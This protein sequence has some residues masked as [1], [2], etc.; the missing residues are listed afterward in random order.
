VVPVSRRRLHAPAAWFTAGV[1]DRPDPRRLLEPILHT[2]ARVNG[3]CRPDRILEEGVG[4]GALD[5][6]DAATGEGKIRVPTGATTRTPAIADG[7]VYVSTFGGGEAEVRALAR[8]E[9][10]SSTPPPLATTTSTRTRRS[11]V[12]P[13]RE[14]R[15]QYEAEL[16]YEALLE[17]RRAG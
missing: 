8:P 12:R 15:S 13:H 17:P 1:P 16:D 2:L 7:V 3:D 5:F 6:L 14:T 10:S 9:R 4:Q 11:A